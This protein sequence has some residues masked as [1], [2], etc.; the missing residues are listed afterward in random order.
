MIV[1]KS[2]VSIVFTSNV[3]EEDTVIYEKLKAEDGI[4]LQRE[5]RFLE[6]L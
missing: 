4:D 6:W 3:L 2:V 5:R 1:A